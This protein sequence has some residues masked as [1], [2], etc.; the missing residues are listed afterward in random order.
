[1]PQIHIS[2]VSDMLFPNKPKAKFPLANVICL[3]SKLRPKNIPTE[4]VVPIKTPNQ[5]FETIPAHF[6]S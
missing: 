1:M 3:I 4:A 6:F 5:I 2:V